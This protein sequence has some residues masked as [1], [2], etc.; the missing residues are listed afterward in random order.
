MSKIF[1][2]AQGWTRYFYSKIGELPKHVREESERRLAIC[3]TCEFRNGVFCSKM[4]T[5]HNE[6]TGQLTQGCG[7]PTKQKS[8]SDNSKCPAGKW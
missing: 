4:K 5:G 3:D 8:L 1:D 7:C 6:I 2:I